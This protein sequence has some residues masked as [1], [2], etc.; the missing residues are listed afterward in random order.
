MSI[1]SNPSVLPGESSLN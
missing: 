1:M